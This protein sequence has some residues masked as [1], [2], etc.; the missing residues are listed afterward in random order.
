[1]IVALRI[2]SVVGI[3]AG[4][5]LAVFSGA[6]SPS[7]AEKRFGLR[8]RKRRR[9]IEQS[10]AFAAVEPWVRLLAPWMGV[11]PLG[12]RRALLEETLAHAGDWLGLD[13]DE[14]LAFSLLHGI[15]GLTAGSFFVWYFDFPGAAV[16]FFG[17][18][19]LV[20]PYIRLTGEV[21]KR[22]KIINRG[23]PGAID[24][25]ALCMT[26]GLAFPQAISQIVSKSGSEHDPLNEELSLIL[27][28]LRL[29]WTREQALRSFGER[30]PS[31]S[32]RSFVNAVVQSE[33]RG[34]PLVEVLQIQAA[35]LRQQRSASGEEA[36]SRAAVLM[37]LPLMLI[38]AA[39]ILLLM[40]PFV[41]QGM[42]SGF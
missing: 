42:E 31:Q 17:G 24:L 12:R 32:V 33:Q 29:G 21:S 26:A 25:A 10:S 41:I 1:M 16:P 36:A 11:V 23:L 38:M 19:G 18:L 7:T 2:L 27:Q 6:S 35:T 39:T 9:A 22:A 8:G 40:G 30:V 4:I 15:A 14:L 20:I 34:T 5:W 3:G 28:Q 37:L 13:V